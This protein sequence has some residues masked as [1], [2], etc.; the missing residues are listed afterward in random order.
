M[1]HEA[2]RLHEPHVSE[3]ARRLALVE[4]LRRDAYPYLALELDSTRA[5]VHHPPHLQARQRLT[6]GAEGQGQRVH[7]EAWVHP[8]AQHRHARL[9]GPGV[10]LAR[11]GR[12][13][14]PGVGQLLAGGDDVLASADGCQ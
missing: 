12:M 7:D 13:V 5:D 8:R 6:Y 11:E 14:L 10:D 4:L 3:V 1:G 9:S 2:G